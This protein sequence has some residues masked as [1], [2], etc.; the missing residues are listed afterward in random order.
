[1]VIFT[2]G[3]LGGYRLSL[4]V[5]NHDLQFCF[6]LIWTSMKFHGTPWNFKDFSGISGYSRKFHKKSYSYYF[7][8]LSVDWLPA[9]ILQREVVR[10]QL[11]YKLI[12]NYSP[13][14]LS[15]NSINLD[16]V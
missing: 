3:V 7:Q 2:L 11:M 15:V 9:V 8:C 12:N 1:M 4:P 13:F 6:D 5:F 16:V 14:R 10:I